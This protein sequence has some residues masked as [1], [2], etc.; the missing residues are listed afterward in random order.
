[1]SLEIAL[2]RWADHVEAGL[3]METLDRL[4]EF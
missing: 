3:D 2:D 1:M 4:V